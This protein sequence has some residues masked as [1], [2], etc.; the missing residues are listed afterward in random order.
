MHFKVGSRN[1]HSG[2]AV[3][4]KFRIYALDVVVLISYKSPIGAFEC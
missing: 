4:G 3:L 1:Y 2:G